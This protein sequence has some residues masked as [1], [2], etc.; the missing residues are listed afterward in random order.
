MVKIRDDTDTGTM[1]DV[2]AGYHLPPAHIDPSFILDL[3]CHAGFTIMDFLKRY[4]SSHIWGVEIDHDNYLTAQENVGDD[5]RVT[6]FEAGIAT[7]D[8]TCSYSGAA[9]NA[10]AIDHSDG[11]THCI[12]LDTLLDGKIDYAKFDI[13]GMERDVFKLGGAWV[14]LVRS[15]KA[16]LHN[17]YM[18]EEA[19]VDL[20]AL[21]YE[22]VVDD[23]HP[24][25]VFAERRS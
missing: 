12:T 8:G 20:R 10:Y 7:W 16:E 9:S 4:P 17:G 11:L 1:R 21:G 18:P 5:D 13:E 3:G 19:C 23:L 22:P 15:L 14:E 6:I 25:A 2:E 24:C